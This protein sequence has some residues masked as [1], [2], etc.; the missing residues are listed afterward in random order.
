[1]EQGW[2]KENAVAYCIE[3]IEN[4][5]TIDSIQNILEI[6]QALFSSKNPSAFYKSVWKHT[7]IEFV[8]S[9]L[10]DVSD[11]DKKIVMKYSE[12]HNI[13]ETSDEFIKNAKKFSECVYSQEY[14]ENENFIIYHTL[15]NLKEY[16]IN[17]FK[18]LLSKNITG[19]ECLMKYVFFNIDKNKLQVPIQEMKWIAPES[20]TLGINSGHKIFS[21]DGGQQNSL[22]VPKCCCFCKSTI[23]EYAFGYKNS[24]YT[25]KIYVSCKN[26]RDFKN[27][28]AWY[29]NLH[30]INYKE[31]KVYDFTLKDCQLSIQQF[32]ELENKK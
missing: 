29:I 13:S 27:Y 32:I 22:S 9:T 31:V 11:E 10:E 6:Y 23:P 5:V 28:C 18:L 25:W 19:P 4:S 3:T 24:V 2:T 20:Y 1:M 14:S 8:N 12:E 26:C 16:I 7:I 17:K 21:F 15:T 30:Y